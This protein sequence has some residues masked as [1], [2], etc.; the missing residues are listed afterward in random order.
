MTNIIN[1]STYFVK[2]TRKAFVNEQTQ[3]NKLTLTTIASVLALT[4]SYYIADNPDSPDSI[5]KINSTDINEKRV[6]ARISKE[7]FATKELK[8]LNAGAARQAYQKIKAA[9]WL[10]SKHKSDLLKMFID[11]IDN[12]QIL[13]KA[14]FIVESYGSLAK[15]ICEFQSVKRGF[16][17]KLDSDSTVNKNGVNLLMDK[18]VNIKKEIVDNLTHVNNLLNKA[19][20]SQIT[21]E[22]L[23]I[24]DKNLANLAE[25]TRLLKAKQK[26]NY[27]KSA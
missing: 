16:V 18:S 14:Q 11:G 15:I 21:A 20:K 12:P 3:T 2:V 27:K 24:V 17:E 5:R 10:F 25:L 19:D 6:R 1:Q 22:L 9:M 26:L 23:E 13:E 7:V 4:A 8:N